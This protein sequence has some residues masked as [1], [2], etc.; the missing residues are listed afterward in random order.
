MLFFLFES[1]NMSETSLLPLSPGLS[2]SDEGRDLLSYLT[3]WAILRVFSPTLPPSFS[4]CLL[5]CLA[6][7]PHHTSAQTTK[8]LFAASERVPACP[9]IPTSG[10]DSLPHCYA[11]IACQVPFLFCSLVC[12]HF[13][14]W[15]FF[16]FFLSPSFSHSL[17]H[18]SFLCWQHPL[19]LCSLV[20]VP[21]V[22]SFFAS[23]FFKTLVHFHELYSQCFFT[24][25]C[26]ITEISTHTGAA[27]LDLVFV[28]SFVFI[29]MYLLLCS[30]VMNVACWVWVGSVFLAFLCVC[31]LQFFS[32][33]PLLF[34]HLV[35]HSPIGVLCVYALAV[36]SV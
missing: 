18:G 7:P 36:S 25:T 31:M 5:A 33:L 17:F 1:A 23:S 29:C 13:L 28:V 14:F 10:E 19:S 2:V 8:T 22:A 3:V 11:L 16:F 12:L 34:H 9:S 35:Y 24:V 21:L 26:H 30:T 27:A 32:S 4:P 20:Q 15:F 6:V